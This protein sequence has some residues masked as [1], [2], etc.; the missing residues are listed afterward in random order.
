M[1][2]NG[3]ADTSRKTA[4]W[5]LMTAASPAGVGTIANPEPGA[6]VLGRLAGRSARGLVRSTS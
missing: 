1:I 3:L 4:P 2:A 6:D 5:M